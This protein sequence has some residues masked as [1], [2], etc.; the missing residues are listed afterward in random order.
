MD[1]TSEDAHSHRRILYHS[2]EGQQANK[3]RTWPAYV[4]LCTYLAMTNHIPEW[5]EKIP[6]ASIDTLLKS[7]RKI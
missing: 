1:D 5:I 2:S 3:I 6:E 4:M 7:R